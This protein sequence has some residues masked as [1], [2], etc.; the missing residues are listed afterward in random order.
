V[1]NFYKLE[2][3][4]YDFSGYN[5]LVD[6]PLD[7]RDGCLHLTDR[8]GLGIELNRE[9]LEKYEVSGADAAK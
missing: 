1:P 6:Q 7:V 2:C 3:H 9:T 4:R 5:I 8:P